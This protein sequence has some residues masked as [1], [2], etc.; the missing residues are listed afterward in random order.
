[1]SI[2][3]SFKRTIFKI[4][5]IVP[6]ESL[7]WKEHRISG[8]HRKPFIIQSSLTNLKLKVVFNIK[9]VRGI[10]A[11]TSTNTERYFV[12]S[13]D[14]ISPF[15]FFITQLTIFELLNLVF[16]KS[17][18]DKRGSTTV[19]SHVSSTSFKVNTRLLSTYSMV[20]LLISEIRIV[21]IISCL[22][23]ISRLIG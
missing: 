8:H 7:F 18:S 9:V 16:K 10:H 19:A 3:N 20:Y 13:S 17:S 21:L 4:S 5:I 22:S 23:V 15:L 12:L 1:M 14:T 2:V 6:S 11:H